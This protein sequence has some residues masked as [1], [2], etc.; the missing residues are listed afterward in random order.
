MRHRIKQY[1]L[2][3]EALAEMLGIVDIY[4]EILAR[5]GGLMKYDMPIVRW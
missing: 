2:S 5:E 1:N 4:E 3:P